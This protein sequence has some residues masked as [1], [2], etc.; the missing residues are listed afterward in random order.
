MRVFSYQNEISRRPTQSVATSEELSW[1]HESRK[2]KPF[3]YENTRV[4]ERKVV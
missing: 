1:G 2:K 3:C 4:L